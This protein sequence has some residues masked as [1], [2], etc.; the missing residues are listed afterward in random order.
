MHGRKFTLQ[1]DHRPLLT[2]FDSKNIIPI[3]TAN[4][5]QSCGIIWLNYNFKMEFLSLKIGY[6]DGLS[7][8]I[9]KFSEPWEDTVIAAL[10]DEKEFSVLLCNTIRELSVTREDS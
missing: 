1:T 5:L 6:A 7:R 9:P 4:R 3:H 10:R 2:I 8:L